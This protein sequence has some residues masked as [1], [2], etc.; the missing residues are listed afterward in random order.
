MI[1]LRARTPVLFYQREGRDIEV[2][3][4]KLV[5]AFIVI[6]EKL[7]ADAEK[8]FKALQAAH[9]K[10]MVTLA[11]VKEAPAKAVSTTTG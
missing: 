6:T 5:A 3:A 11:E 2:A 4:E 8:P 7:A 9:T 1:P 10:R